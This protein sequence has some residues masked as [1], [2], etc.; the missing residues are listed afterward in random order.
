ME[1]TNLQVGGE[2]EAGAF[3]TWPPQ[4][5]KSDETEEK[6]QED[7]LKAA[8]EANNTWI[9]KEKEYELFLVNGQSGAS[10]SIL[11]PATKQ[12]ALIVGAKFA[13]ENSQPFLD[14]L[15]FGLKDVTDFNTNTV[16]SK[17]KNTITRDAALFRD[18]LQEGEIVEIDEFGNKSEPKTFKRNDLLDMLEPEYQSELIEQWLG[19]FHIERFVD[20]SASRI[21]SILKSDTLQFLC[22][23]GHYDTPRHVLLFEFTKPNADARRTYEEK[24]V[25]REKEVESGKTINHLKIVAEEKRRFAIKYFSSVQGVTVDDIGKPFD[26]TESSKTGFKKGFNPHWWVRLADAMNQAYSNVGKR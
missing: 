2:G 26:N 8:R 24:T 15:D 7:P 12:P 13:W 25:I 9:F 22:R 10:I 20:P 23:I 4:P 5:E 3:Q 21:Q 1:E 17:Q 14:H 6:K 18:I 16:V 11:D 19:N